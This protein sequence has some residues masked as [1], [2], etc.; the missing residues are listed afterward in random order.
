VAFQ[1]L[2]HGAPPPVGHI[3]IKCHII[4]DA[5]MDFERKSRF[6]GGHMTDPLTTITYSNVV[7]RDSIW[8]AF[9]VVALHDLCEYIL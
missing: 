8:I 3:L 6:V 5:Q 2:G 9:V 1:P 4:F 7:S